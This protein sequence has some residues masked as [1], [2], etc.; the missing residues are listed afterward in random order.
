MV[1]VPNCC[2]MFRFKLARSFA[3]IP[4][5]EDHQHPV[6][7]DSERAMNVGD[8][9]VTKITFEDNRIT[10]FS[11]IF[12]TDGFQD[13][14]AELVSSIP[15][16]FLIGRVANSREM[17]WIKNL[18]ATSRGNRH[19][20]CIDLKTKNYEQRDEAS[21]PAYSP[22]FNRSSNNNDVILETAA[23]SSLPILVSPQ[24]P[25]PSPPSMPRAVITSSSRFI[26]DTSAL[27][28][29]FEW[30]FYIQPDETSSTCS[31][32]FH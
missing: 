11:L 26:L 18:A 12:P 27:T 4:G 17:E 15:P 28:L 24:P 9:G 32:L 23:P 22:S 30:K 14:A 2:V 6:P 7:D 13:P 16:A 3:P 20:L 25:P 5:F 10:G 1:A 21:D 31:S 29:P 8:V 19:D